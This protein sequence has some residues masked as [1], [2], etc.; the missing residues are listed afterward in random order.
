MM[1]DPSDESLKGII[2]RAFSHIFGSI[3]STSNKNFLIRS[4]YIEIYNEEIHDL[5]GPDVKAKL[6]L[7]ESTE[8]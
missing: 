2:P 3:D 6:E 8:T 7:K 5:I 1:G 4:S